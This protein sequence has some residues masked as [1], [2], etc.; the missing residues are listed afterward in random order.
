MRDAEREVQSL[1]PYL[2]Q[3]PCRR[4]RAENPLFQAGF[5]LGQLVGHYPQSA[6]HGI[7][8]ESRVLWLL[9]AILP[10]RL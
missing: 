2:R 3:I 4:M 5:H 6:L 1:T 7:K 9:P 8:L 10:L